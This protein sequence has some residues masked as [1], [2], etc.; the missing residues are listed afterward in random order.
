T[1][2]LGNERLIVQSIRRS[3]T[4]NAP[5][6]A[7]AGCKVAG[8]IG[9]L[10]PLALFHPGVPAGQGKPQL[11]L[12]KAKFILQVNAGIALCLDAS[13]SFRPYT[14]R[15]FAVKCRIPVD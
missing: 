10:P 2:G 15:R 5:A 1:S 8:L 4:V 13:G 6:E 9:R 12:K 11:V 14:Q 3:L 7:D